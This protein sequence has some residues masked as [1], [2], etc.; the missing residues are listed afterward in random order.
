MLTNMKLRLTLTLNGARHLSSRVLD[1]YLQFLTLAKKYGQGPFQSV[2]D[3]NDGVTWIE[4]ASMVDLTSKTLNRFPTYLL[5]A[6]IAKLHNKASLSRTSVLQMDG[7][8]TSSA[9]SHSVD[10]LQTQAMGLTSNPDHDMNGHRFVD[11]DVM[12]EVLIEAYLDED[13]RMHH[14]LT[15][16]FLNPNPTAAG[17]HQQRDRKS[18]HQQM[19]VAPNAS[20]ANNNNNDPNAAGTVELVRSSSNVHETLEPEMFSFVHFCDVIRALGCS[21]D[22][23]RLLRVYQHSVQRA[24]HRPVTIE[25][26]VLTVRCYGLMPV[27]VDTELVEQSARATR[28]NDIR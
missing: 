17:I 26:F 16:L 25:D 14:M 11:F 13:A 22:E 6:T 27:E 8:H 1:F 24:I 2:S 9:A 18:L 19:N 21:W 12:M 15:D 5:R 4:L 23:D 28:L 20:N 7:V 10:V 3:N